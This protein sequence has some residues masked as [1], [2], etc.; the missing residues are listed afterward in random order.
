MSEAERQKRYEER[1]LG[2]EAGTG[3]LKRIEELP[4]LRDGRRKNLTNRWSTPP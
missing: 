3:N 4:S 2:E 1:T